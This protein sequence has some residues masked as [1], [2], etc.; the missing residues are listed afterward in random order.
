[1]KII[2]AQKLKELRA[3]KGCT[4]EDLAEYLSISVPSVSKWERAESYPDITFLPQIAAYYNV[5]VDD[6][7]GVGEIRKQERLDWYEA[8]SQ[9]LRNIGKIPEEVALWRE[10]LK[11]FPNEQ[12]VI[13]KLARAISFHSERNDEQIKE[14]I[15]LRVSS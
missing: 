6:P 10:T 13:S 5:S 14:V 2:I 11:E 1:M 7:L 8:E 15:K 9:K 3:A 12:L 4:Q